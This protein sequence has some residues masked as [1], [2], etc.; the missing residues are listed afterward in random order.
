M[1]FYFFFLIIFW[2]QFMATQVIAADF[3]VWAN[4]GLDKVT[5]DEM[6]LTKGKDVRNSVW[7]ESNV[8]IFGASNE[9]VS[10]N[11]IL[12][13]SNRD[14][15]DVDVKISELKNN[16]GSI[17]H[18]QYKNK[19]DIFDY[20]GR[21]IEIFVVKYLQIIGLSRLAYSPEY[22][23][24]HV[25]ERLQLPYTMI[26]S[27]PISI[28]SFKDRPGA[29]KYYPD[30]AVPIE[31]VKNLSVPRN[32]N[33]SFWVD[34]YIPK[35]TPPG[36]YNATIS[37]SES[38]AVRLEVPVVLTVLPFA[39]PDT[40]HAKTMVWI[41]EP[42]INFR[43]TG[44]RWSDSG[45]ATPE[46]KKTMDLVM[47]RHFQMAKRH[48]I[49][50]ITDGMDIFYQRA[51]DRIRPIYNGEL[52]S[53]DMG[54]SGPGEMMPCDVYSVGTYGA[55]R[56]LK[57]WDKDSQVSMWEH[58]DHI[59]NFFKNNFKDVEYFLYL[60]D[61]P[62]KEK[63]TD[64]EKWAGW[65]KSN[66]GI[67]YMLP[68][69]CTTSLLN[70]QKFM[71]SLSIALDGWGDKDEWMDAL[72]SNNNTK[73]MVT[74]GGRPGTGSFMIEDDGVALRV[75][76]WIQF[77]HQIDRWFYWASTNYRNPSRVNYE[78]NVFKESM[79]FGRK[80]DKIH[81]KYG[82]TGNGYGN[83]D[84]VLFY[85]GTD[86]FFTDESYELAGPIASLRMKMWRRG[87][88]DYEYL[89]LAS[90]RNFDAVKLLVHA[91]V[92]VSLWELGVTDKNDPTYIHADISWTTDPNKW[93]N[94]RRQLSSIIME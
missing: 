79:T 74:N 71:P 25:P 58:A 36:I 3:L 15:I 10:F 66:P 83:G 4:D 44:V 22:D 78:T 86:T 47:Y 39:L 63:F 33:Q 26:L 55:W 2:S 92:P 42:D 57:N 14:L 75:N 48:R 35:N 94:A 20:V 89:K 8:S 41:N 65:V 30:I 12:E 69:F 72:E 18:N 49:S 64:V 50:L 34:I 31:V 73:L 27:K 1:K 56:N 19:D 51:I 67:G 16:M 70:K 80:S 23:E 62:Q 77:K 9:F 38:G 32:E 87:L 68:T 28:G 7:N 84:G 81:P 59:V 52:F 90:E 24:R 45:A 82:E 17:I 88:Q 54:Y 29:F 40:F 43:Y 6:R 11:V 13:A 46:K 61:E 53:K 21:N 60:W 37:I 93:E 5:K 91:M 76:G 85:P